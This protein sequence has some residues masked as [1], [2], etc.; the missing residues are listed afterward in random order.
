MFSKDRLLNIQQSL[1]NKIKV[2][3]YDGYILIFLLLLSLLGIGMTDAFG[4][5]SKWYWL[6][7][8]PI[9][10]GCNLFVEWQSAKGKNVKFMT[11]LTQ[12]IQYWIGLFGAV[13][14][15]FFLEE[16]GSF[17]NETTGMILLLI[18][19]LSIFQTGVTTGWLFQLLGVFLGLS[20]MIVAYVENYTWAI[21][22]LSFIVLLVYIYMPSKTKPVETTDR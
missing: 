19:A 12:Q 20:L 13:Y 6:A 14:L 21:L 8:I 9:F 1:H 10:Y 2:I 18:L 15:T 17:N 3:R 4:Y 7:M 11:L 5:W 22:A 16:I